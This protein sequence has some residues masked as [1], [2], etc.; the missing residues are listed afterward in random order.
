MRWSILAFPSVA[1]PSILAALPD[2]A[3]C[4]TMVELP[5]AVGRRAA[6]TRRRCFTPVIDPPIPHTDRG[7]FPTDKGPSRTE[8]CSMIARL[9]LLGYIVLG[10]AIALE[11]SH[12]PALDDRLP[13]GP[14]EEL[15]PRSPALRD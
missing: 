13:F 3:G 4:F 14:G 9:V 5:H 8:D 6:E 12:P 11:P 10:A 2:H 1:M 15:T 7:N